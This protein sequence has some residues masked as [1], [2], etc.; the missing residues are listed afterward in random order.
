MASL[1]HYLETLASAQ[2]TPGGGSAATIVAAMAASLVAMVARVTAGNPKFAIHLA[3][4]SL[5]VIHA[6]GLRGTLLD[7]RVAD[8]RAYGEVVAAT[9]LPRATDDEK[10][11]RIERVQ[12]ALAEAARVPLAA[13]AT[14]LSVLGLATRV[15]AFGNTNLMSDV[16]CAAAF[17]RAAIEASAA[18]VRVNHLFLKDTD[19]VAAQERDL[20]RIEDDARALYSEAIS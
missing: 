15:R 1:E 16:V 20:A 11:A 6:D 19:L 4:A 7:A 2:P 3:E 10:R 14:T 17:A 13:A 18:N 12:S 8:E 9:A 5:I